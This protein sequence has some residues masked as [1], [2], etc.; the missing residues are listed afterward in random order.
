MIKLAYASQC[1][2]KRRKLK[3]TDNDYYRLFGNAVS[4]YRRTIINICKVVN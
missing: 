1:S 2:F 4:S 3:K